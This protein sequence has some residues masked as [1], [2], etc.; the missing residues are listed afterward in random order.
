M[1]LTKKLHDSPEAIEQAF[2]DALEHADLDALMAL[3]SDEDEIVYIP[4]GGARLLGHHA[5]REAWRA[6]FANGPV[7]VRPTNTR[8]MQSGMVSLHSVIEQV[9]VQANGK[10]AVVHLVASNVF[11]KGPRGWR[12]V[13]HHAS[14]IPEETTARETPPGLLH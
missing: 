9:M 13:L 8:V 4:P 5:V 10:P 7:H 12:L 2:Y 14:P 3:W 1:P 11:I 6:T